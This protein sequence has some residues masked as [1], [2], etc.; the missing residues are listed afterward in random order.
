MAAGAGLNFLIIK[1]HAAR[2]RSIARKINGA[3][4]RNDTIEGGEGWDE[5]GFPFLRAVAMS[6]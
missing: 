2:T 3:A 5:R 6:T 4:T 1:A